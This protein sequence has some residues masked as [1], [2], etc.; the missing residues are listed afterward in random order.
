MYV[1]WKQYLYFQ[2][3]YIYNKNNPIDIQKIKKKKEKKMM[4]IEIIL[5][6]TVNV[7]L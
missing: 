5:K 6:K 4:F 2:Q 1:P 7:Y 3:S